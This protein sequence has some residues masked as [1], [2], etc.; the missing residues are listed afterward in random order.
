MSENKAVLEWIYEP[1]TFFEHV[2]LRRCPF[3][4]KVKNG[5][6]RIQLKHYSNPVTSDTLESVKNTL[7]L[8]FDARTF[9]CIAG[10]NLVAQQFIITSLMDVKVL[11]Y[12]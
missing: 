10:T 5:R 4:L 9:F 8:L 11:R 1:E 12:L 6:V 7:L 2:F 3:Y